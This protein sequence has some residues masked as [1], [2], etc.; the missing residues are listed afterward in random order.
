MGQ[1]GR[2][3]STSDIG[4]VSE[5]SHVITY[6]LSVFKPYTNK[7]TLSMGFYVKNKKTGVEPLHSPVS[8]CAHKG[9][10]PPKKQRDCRYSGKFSAT[11]R[12]GVR[13]KPKKGVLRY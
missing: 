9:A 2:G 6:K 5:C 7:P 10:D 3:P 13:G 4:S 1:R 8:F 12:K 11:V